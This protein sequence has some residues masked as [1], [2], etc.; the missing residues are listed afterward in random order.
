MNKCPPHGDAI[1]VI[2]TRVAPV[3]TGAMSVNEFCTAYGIGRTLTYAEIK[4]GKLKPVKI[5]RRTLIPVAAAADWLDQKIS[6]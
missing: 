2:T 5:G 3:A 1:G 6:A 4:A